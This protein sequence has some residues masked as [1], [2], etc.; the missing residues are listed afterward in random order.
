MV[1]LKNLK[2]DQKGFVL[3]IWKKYQ[4]IPEKKLESKATSKNI[5]LFFI[6]LKI[7]VYYS[8]PI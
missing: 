2:K 7:D 1:P 3:K 5:V 8:F 6:L 4:R